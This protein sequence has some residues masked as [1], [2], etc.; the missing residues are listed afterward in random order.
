MNV[1]FVTT[2][3][4]PFTKTG[5]LA[6]VSYSLPRALRSLGVDVRVITSKSFRMAAEFAERE[7]Q[8]ATF[9]VAVGWRNQYAGLS[10][11]EHNDI[12]YYFIDNEYYFKRDSLY[13]HFDDGERF[14]FFSKAVLEA[15]VHMEDFKPDIIHLNDW[16]TSVIPV[17]MRDQYYDHPI[18]P[19]MKTMLTIH[20]LRFQ[21]VFDKKFMGDVLSLGHSYHADEALSYKGA[22]NFLKGGIERANIVNTVSPTYSKEIMTEFFGEGLHEIISARSHKIYGILNGIDR[23]L[24]DPNK[25]PKLQANYNLRS[26]KGKA[27]NKAYLQQ[28][29][30]LPVKEDTPLIA[31]VTRLDE[32]KGLDLIMGIFEELIHEDIQLMVLGVGHPKYEEFFARKQVEYPDKFSVHLTFSDQWAHE[33]YG[34]ADMLLMPSKFEPCGLSQQIAMRYGTVPIVRETG[35]LKDT[36]TPYNKYDQT[37]NGFS[38]GT[39]SAH[40]MFFAIQKALDVY[41]DPKAWKNLVKSAMKYDSSWKTSAEAYKK[42]YES[43]MEV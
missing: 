41:H 23:D 14:A 22:I 4:V 25:D 28:K 15:T 29:S 16:H 40:E 30:G 17:L 12:P 20:N 19:Y 10:K 38:F 36:V 37:G 24:Y 2:E 13:G 3:V 21:G 26:L 34:G 32:M 43:L 1:L 7:E 5:G 42:L 18:V 11:L 33:I 8:I 31:I 39:Y 9:N 35:G 27:E 6:D